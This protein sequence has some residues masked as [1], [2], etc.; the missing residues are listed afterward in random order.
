[1]KFEDITGRRFGR[2]TAVR[3]APN[4]GRR[5]MWHCK[6]ECGND[7]VVRAEN[8]KSGN[9]KSCG[10]IERDFPNATKHGMSKTR[11]AAVYNAMKQRCYNENS[12]GYYLYGGRGIK[13][14]DEWL[15]DKTAF[16]DWAIANGYDDSSPQTECSLDRVDVNAGYSPENCRWVDS[17][18]QANN[19]RK[20]KHY[21]YNGENRTLAEWSRSSGI[22]YSALYARVATLG[23]TI[24]DAINTP[25]KSRR[26]TDM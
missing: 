20:N 15:Q 8:L 2:L 11:L 26:T 3:R 4:D 5:T 1:M 9:T 24:E 18:T 7:V 10:C 16:F 14:C 23:W 19:T 22:P 25:L 13:V 6:C 17:Y 12:S 21:Y